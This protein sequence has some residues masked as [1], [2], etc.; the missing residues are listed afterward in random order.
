MCSGAGLDVSGVGRVS[1]MCMALRLLGVMFVEE[2]FIRLAYEF[3]CAWIGY[4][5]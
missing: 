1:G 2:A 4:W 3:V 5:A